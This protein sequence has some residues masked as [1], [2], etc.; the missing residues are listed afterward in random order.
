MDKKIIDKANDI[1]GK[2]ES[3]KKAIKE[4]EKYAE[5]GKTLFTQYMAYSCFGSFN[6]SIDFEPWE[7][8]LMIHNKKQRI[9]ALEKQL[10]QL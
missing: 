7:I 10:E 4:L 8:R 3:N 1:I 9:T 6:E 2:I 5:S